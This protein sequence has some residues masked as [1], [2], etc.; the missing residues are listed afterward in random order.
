M[1]PPH[2]VLMRG[3]S[4]AAGFWPCFARLRNGRGN[5]ASFGLEQDFNSVDA[6]YDALPRLYSRPSPFGRCCG[7]NTTDDGIS[8]GDTDRTALRRLLEDVQAIAT[9]TPTVF[10]A[11][12]AAIE[13]CRPTS[14]F[15]DPSLAMAGVV[16]KL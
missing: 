2:A 1:Q 5:D 4:P 14:T 16:L 12:L 10:I 6:Q 8:G 9:Y 13:I 11:P 3:T 7:S 15:A